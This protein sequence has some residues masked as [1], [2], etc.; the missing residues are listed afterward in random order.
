ML[1]GTP[2]LPF[3][4][5]LDDLLIVEQNMIERRT[6]A[7]SLLG[8]N[9]FILSMTCFPHLGVEDSIYPSSEIYPLSSA[10]K[11]LYV[12]DDAMHD[13]ARFKFE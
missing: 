13:H 7:Q 1:E 4:C 3:G 5:M 8:S 6:L 12:P 2:G 11:S 9:E 10:S